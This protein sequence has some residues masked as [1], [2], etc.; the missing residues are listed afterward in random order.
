MG[1][2]GTTTKPAVSG[3]EGAFS[4]SVGETTGL[5]T[6]T[7]AVAK[8]GCEKNALK[9]MRSFGFR[10][11]KLWRRSVSSLEVPA[12]ILMKRQKMAIS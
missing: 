1:M 11:N 5:G 4:S 6:E 3:E 10:F 12:G 2:G 9:S 8:K 7:G